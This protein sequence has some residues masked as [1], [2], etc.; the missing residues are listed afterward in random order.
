MK[1]LV[2]RLTMLFMA[3]ALGFVACEKAP[4]EEPKPEP[5]PAEGWTCS[6]GTTNTGKFC[7]NCGKPRA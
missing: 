3:L 4:V 7:Q 6:C 1:T 5:K 2:S